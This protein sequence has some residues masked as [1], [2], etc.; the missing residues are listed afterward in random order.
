MVNALAAGTVSRIYKDIGDQVKRGDVLCEL[1]SF[2]FLELKKRYIKAVQHFRLC[3]QYHDNAKELFKI[4]GIEQKELLK[5]ETECKKSMAEYF[6]LESDLMAKGLSS[7]Y[8]EF[9]KNSL[10]NEL[11]RI[12]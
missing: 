6:S 5:R 1:N 2:E 10:R 9:I 12:L 8:L 4:K 3:K 11:K 7:Q